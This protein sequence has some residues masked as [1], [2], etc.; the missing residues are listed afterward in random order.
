M[1]IVTE[2]GEDKTIED[3]KKNYP[4]EIE[5]LKEV[6]LYYVGNNDPN[7]LKTKF[8]DKSKHLTEKIANPY[9]FFNSIEDYQKPVDNLKKQYFFSKLKN[10]YPSDKENEGTK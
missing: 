5:K 3:L 9:D 7:L 10:D 4:N 1:N 8:S 2:I 6:L